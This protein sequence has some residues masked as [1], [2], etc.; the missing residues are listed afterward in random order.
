[1]RIPWEIDD[2]T[3]I[4]PS[5]S[6]AG[7][8]DIGDG[9]AQQLSQQVSEFII[10]EL[11]KRTREIIPG[12]AI[13]WSSLRAENRSESSYRVEPRDGLPTEFCHRV[14]LE[15]TG[16]TKLWR[17]PPIG[18][19]TGVI[20]HN[21]IDFDFC[22]TFDTDE[23][24]RARF[25]VT[26]NAGY[27]TVNGGAIC[28]IVRNAIESKLGSAGT[29]QQISSAVSNAINEPLRFT[30]LASFVNLP[31]SR[32]KATDGNSCESTLFADLDPICLFVEDRDEDD[33]ST[34]DRTPLPESEQRRLDR[35]PA[36][37]QR[38]NGSGCFWRIPV[39]RVEAIP[40]GL[41]LVFSEDTTDSFGDFSDNGLIQSKLGDICRDSSASQYDTDDYR[42]TLTSYGRDLSVEED[43]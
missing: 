2:D 19:I 41:I 10:D 1:M 27:A 15:G 26:H 35:L 34:H 21:S 42:D 20:C 25:N 7:F 39:R 24:N 22:G 23:N 30:E 5:S 9:F 31:L 14:R 11:G 4:P 17:T 3:D 13:A 33:P 6:F 12:F 36:N 28:T 40:S 32:C 37:D 29:A 16:T 18:P 8:D 43:H 38:R